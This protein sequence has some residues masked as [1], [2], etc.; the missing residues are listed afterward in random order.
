MEG[1]MSLQ[2]ED[3]ARLRV[4]EFRREA[5]NAPLLKNSGSEGRLRIIFPRLKRALLLVFTLFFG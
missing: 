1:A 2:D 4:A 3:L 5:S